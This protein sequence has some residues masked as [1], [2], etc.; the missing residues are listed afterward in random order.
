MS[1]ATIEQ[2]NPVDVVMDAWVDN[3]GT[4]C[5]AQEQGDKILRNWMDQGAVTRTESQKMATRFA[6]QVKQNQAEMQKF[7]HNSVKMSL[8]TMRRAQEMQIEALNKRVEEMGRTI[9]KMTD[10]K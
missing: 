10:K 6:E 8:E 3:L 5:W 1:N 7:I 2:K 9:D 4:L